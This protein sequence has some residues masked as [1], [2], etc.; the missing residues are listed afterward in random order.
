MKRSP[1]PTALTRQ[2]MRPQF[3]SGHVRRRPGPRRAGEP[4]PR[5]VPARADR[6]T[7]EPT[8]RTQHRPPHPRSPLRGTQAP[9]RVVPC[10]TLIAVLRESCRIAIAIGDGSY[11]GIS[12]NLTSG[13]NA[14]S[15]GMTPPLR[16]NDLYRT[17]LFSAFSA[18]PTVREFP[19]AVG[20]T[21]ATNAGSTAT[22]RSGPPSP[23]GSS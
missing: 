23:S 22:S 19:E 16:S 10:R 21:W 18:R 3:G 9:R 1:I 13:Y 15:R 5:A 14:C 8:P 4:V 12:A 17:P 2:R 20:P 7:G 6:R 11:P